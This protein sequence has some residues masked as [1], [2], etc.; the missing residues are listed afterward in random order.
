MVLTSSNERKESQPAL[1][2]WII[3]RIDNCKFK[4]FPGASKLSA[5]GDGLESLA[6]GCKGSLRVLVTSTYE[7]Q[8]LDKSWEDEDEDSRRVD[9]WV[10]IKYNSR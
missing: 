4:G 6:R 8:R 10:E 9:N 1:I 5:F 3:D 7:P 2:F